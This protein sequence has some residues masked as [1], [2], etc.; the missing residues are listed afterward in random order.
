MPWC[1]NKSIDQ[2]HPTKLLLQTDMTRHF[3]ATT[4]P[5]SPEVAMFCSYYNTTIAGIMEDKWISEEFQSFTLH[6]SHI[7]T[8]NEM[9]YD[10]ELKLSIILLIR[11][12]IKIWLH[13]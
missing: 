1:I 7:A 2:T 10:D 9:N 13:S 5:I 6:G 12:R 8:I 4:V 3:T 11:C